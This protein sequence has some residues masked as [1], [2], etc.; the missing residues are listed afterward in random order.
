VITVIN[1][2]NI[3][4]IPREENLLQIVNHQKSRW[5][6]KIYEDEKRLLKRAWH[7]KG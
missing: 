3:F 5:K 6:V 1:P 7:L 2:L 4:G